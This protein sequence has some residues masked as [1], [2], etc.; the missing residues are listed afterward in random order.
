[1]HS[2]L[3]CIDHRVHIRPSKMSWKGSFGVNEHCLALEDCQKVALTNTHYDLDADLENSAMFLV[4]LHN[5]EEGQRIQDKR[6]ETPESQ[7]PRHS[8]QNS[9]R[10]ARSTDDDVQRDS[11]HLMNSYLPDGMPL[12][13]P[14]ILVSLEVLVMRCRGEKRPRVDVGVDDGRGSVVC[15]GTVYYPKGTIVQSALGNEEEYENICLGSEDE[16]RPKRARAIGAATASAPSVE[17]RA[18]APPPFSLPRRST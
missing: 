8:T 7:I 1:M 10:R 11:L 4:H 12:C 14:P 18:L 15:V 2:P 5:D 6:D 17:E 13:R 9:M 16:S 3:A